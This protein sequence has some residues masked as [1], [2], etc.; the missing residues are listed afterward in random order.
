MLVVVAA[1][2]TPTFVQAQSRPRPTPPTS[3]RPTPKAVPVTDSDRDGVIDSRDACPTDPKKF[4]NAGICGCRVA[5]IDLDSDGVMDCKDKCANTPKASKVDQAGCPVVVD[6]DGDGVT[7][8]KDACPKDSKKSKDAGLCGCGMGDDDWDFD[9]IAD[10]KDNCPDTYN[11]DQTDSLQYGMGDDCLPMAA[12]YNHTCAVMKD[13]LLKCWGENS[14]GQSGKSPTKTTEPVEVKGVPGKIRFLAGS[15]SRT[16]AVNDTGEVYCWGAASFDNGSGLDPKTLVPGVPYKIPF[17]EKV[18]SIGMGDSQTC[19][20]T[21]GNKVY[22]WGSGYNYKLGTGTIDTAPTATDAVWVNAIGGH[23][24][25]DGMSQGMKTCGIDEKH[26]LRC[27]GGSS[28]AEQ[29]KPAEKKLAK[30]LNGFKATQLHGGYTRVCS[31]FSKKND[32]KAVCWD[33]NNYSAGTGKATQPWD[34]TQAMT[35]VFQPVSVAA[36]YMADCLVQLDGVVKCTGVDTLAGYSANEMVGKPINYT[37]AAIPF[38]Q[39]ALKVVG[40]G[41]HFCAR[42]DDLSVGCW[43]NNA[44]GQVGSVKAAFKSNA[45]AAEVAPAENSEED[46]ASDD[47][48]DAASDDASEEA[49]EEAPASRAY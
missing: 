18:R 19:L 21:Q 42:F 35:G 48:S 49:V 20:V 39:G 44:S 32:G 7:D 37:P 14:S 38:D 2:L 45:P 30:E 36:G 16:C 6:S 40:G 22:C 34:D 31:I 10:C 47:A 41:A 46:K 26:S 5:D 15:F 11:P 13:G 28:V 23:V 1:S 33:N 4:K 3:N 24:A 9:S 8:D 27:W 29:A 25:V 17:A 43:G 12:G